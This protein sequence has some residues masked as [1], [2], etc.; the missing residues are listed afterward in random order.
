MRK[1]REPIAELINELRCGSRATM[2]ARTAARAHACQSCRES[3]RRDRLTIATGH[4]YLLH[5]AFPDGE[6]VVHGNRPWTIN[7]CVSC[8][9]DRNDSWPAGACETYCCIGNLPCAMPASHGGDHSCR[10]CMANPL[11]PV[12]RPNGKVYQPRK[13]VRAMEVDWNYGDE[14]RIAVFGTHDIDRAYKLAASIWSDDVYQDTAEQEW[15]RLV[16]RNGEHRYEHDPVRGAAVVI[17]QVG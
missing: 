14:T 10:F 3:G 13:P 15:W 4:R 12:T 9:V 5:T 16:M 6:T 7:E 17:F 1:A 2:K 11:P 8:A